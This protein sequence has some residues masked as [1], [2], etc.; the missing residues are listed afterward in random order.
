MTGAHRDGPAREA[1]E[2]ARE[3]LR[4]LQAVGA[5][6]RETPEGR[7]RLTGA[8][9]VPGALLR[10]VAELGDAVRAELGPGEPCGSCGGRAF[11][12]RGES[13]RCVR[14][15][16]VPRVG[17]LPERWALAGWP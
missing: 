12:Q 10:R 15:A 14:C 5:T 1:R 9:K 13:W 11:Y 8:G 7:L 3:L 4:A 2:D 16:G 17:A 6:V